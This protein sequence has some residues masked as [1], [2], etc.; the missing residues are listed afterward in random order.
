MTYPQLSVITK[1]SKLYRYIQLHLV[2]IVGCFCYTSLRR[3]TMNSFGVYI[4]RL[5]KGSES[6]NYLRC[7]A[8]NPKAL[9]TAYSD[10]QKCLWGPA[11]QNGWQSSRKCGH[12]NAKKRITKI[13]KCDHKNR[14]NQNVGSSSTPKVSRRWSISFL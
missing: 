13:Q 1:L 6:R 8:S 4:S 11:G 2:Y 7:A 3:S 10:Y 12:S 9:L 5:R 14:K